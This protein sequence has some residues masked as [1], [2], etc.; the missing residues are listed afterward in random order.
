LAEQ[1]LPY[2]TALAKSAGLKLVLMR[3]YALPP[4]ATGEEY[5]IYTEELVKQIESDA[6]EYVQKKIEEAKRQ[7]LGN[8]DSVVKFGYG[9]TEIIAVAHETAASF[10]AMC[11]HG[12]S[13]INRWVL[14]SV[15]ERVVRHSGDPVLI[16]RA[17]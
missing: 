16:V 13:G 4:S 14:G 15:T 12:R 3:A 11:T 9:A 10:V 7:G 6:L 1:V 2:A 5:G 8:I 17:L